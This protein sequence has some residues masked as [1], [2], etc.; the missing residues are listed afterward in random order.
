MSGEE[1]TSGAE[2]APA[3]VREIEYDGKPV[4]IEGGSAPLKEFRGFFSGDDFAHHDDDSDDPADDRSGVVSVVF[5]G[6]R[7]DLHRLPSGYLH[8]H[9][10]PFQRFSSADEAAEFI[11]RM[12]QHG[13]IYG[14]PAEPQQT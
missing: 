6:Q 12:A 13:V 9:D 10:L 7:F 1:P 8:S 3:D 14:R 5:E 4:R 2:A 11:A